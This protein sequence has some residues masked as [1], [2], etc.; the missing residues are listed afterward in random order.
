MNFTICRFLGHD[1][2]DNA[3][4]PDWRGEMQVAAH[5]HLL[6]RW[7]DEDGDLAHSRRL[8]VDVRDL[9]GPLDAG[10]LVKCGLFPALA[11]DGPTREPVS[12]EPAG[13]HDAILAV[14]Q[15]VLAQPPTRRL[16][17]L[18]AALGWAI[19]DVADEAALVTVADPA[20]DETHAVFSSGSSAIR[21][22]VTG[23]ASPGNGRD[24]ACSFAG[25]WCEAHAPLPD[26]DLA[27][28]EARLRAVCA[29]TILR[30]PLDLAGYAAFRVDLAAHTLPSGLDVTSI[31]R[32]WRSTA[33][34]RRYGEEYLEDEFP[35]PGDRD[36]GPLELGDP[37]AEGWVLGMGP[38]PLTTTAFLAEVEAFGATCRQEAAGHAAGELVP[39]L[40]HELLD[41]PLWRAGG[42]QGRL[43]VWADADA[44][45]RFWRTPGGDLDRYGEARRL[46]V[47]GP[48]EALYV[49]FKDEKNC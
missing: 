21:V 35:G 19:L 14:R 17:V 9:D 36:G 28:A 13:V 7:L 18:S 47:V 5:A 40:L 3:V 2:H 48:A 31:R 12:C 23:P 1:C 34:S 43:L 37:T 32:W 24:P 30:A 26:G 39:Y 33:W 10:S 29:G 15:A 11:P 27:R 46:L 44:G 25:H 8:M 41:E 42:P 49:V 16:D 22:S 20:R 45:G 4:S 38:R 6:N